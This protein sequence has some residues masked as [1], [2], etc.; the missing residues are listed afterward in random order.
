MGKISVLM[1]SWEHIVLGWPSEIKRKARPRKITTNLGSK[2][3]DLSLLG[4]NKLLEGLLGKI[5]VGSELIKL[6]DVAGVVLL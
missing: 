5:G 3:E 4:L 2:V 6:G 1:G